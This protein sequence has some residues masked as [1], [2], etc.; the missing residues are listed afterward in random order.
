[1]F[2]KTH[3]KILFQVKQLPTHTFFFLEDESLTVEL[4][5]VFYVFYTSFLIH[6]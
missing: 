2:E 4:T 6:S 3:L 5:D 1:M